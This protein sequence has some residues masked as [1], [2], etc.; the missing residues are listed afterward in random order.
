MATDSGLWDLLLRGESHGTLHHW[1]GDGF[2][3]QPW[4]EV[5]VQAHGMAATLREAGVRPGTRVATVLTNSAHTVRGLLAVWLAG[6]AVASFPLSARGQ[7]P[8]EYGNQLT[9]L[10]ERL[11]PTVLLVDESLKRLVPA[12]LAA[13]L[14]MLT[15]TSLYGGG[16]ID[17]SPPGDE[18]TVFI[19][20]SSGST[21]LP[22]GCELS[23]RAVGTHLHMLRELSDGQPGQETIASWLPLSH[24][25]GV[26]GTMLHAWAFDHDFV[27]SSPERFGMA[28]RTWFRDMSEFGAT[29]TA[30]TNTALHLATRAQGRTALPK[31]LRLKAFVMGAERV[32][33]DTLNAA[34]ETFRP[35]GLVPEAFMP[36]Y[37]MA[38]ATLA[39]SSTP[40]GERPSARHF[41]GAALLD[42]RIVEV[43]EDTPGATRLVS[44]GP[45][46]PGV[47]VQQARTGR[48]SELLISTPS[49]AS[50]YHGDPRRTAE[51]FR[52]G[53]LHTGDLGFV[54]D[55]EVFVVGRADDLISVGGRNVHTGDI[56]S[57]VEGLGTVRKG[58]SALVEMT[59]SPVSRLVMLLEPARRSDD[60]HAI[61]NRAAT[62]ALGKSGIALSECVFVERGHL[63][64]TPSGKIQR[65]RCR[66][67]LG[68]DDSP[69]K[70]I[71]RIRLD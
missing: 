13:R 2:A 42:N 33:W 49:L 56:E 24:D 59:G 15:W 50:R 53:A 20:Y 29:M 44:N 62:V 31:P 16:R 38:E 43:S 30:G 9:V 26:F 11:D 66:S 34:V 69:L 12:G 22:K 28:P 36:A 23:V 61:A 57:A 25:M 7:S 68:Q 21:S 47:R 55:G 18:D 51:R 5:V 4:H 3:H 63:P 70:T 64:R 71:A 65:F 58:C 17:P 27:L 54:H 45:P 39:I 48:V 32:D 37:G 67:L 6:G 19:Q 46:L 52:D 60:F 35:S 1:D 40:L 10:S 14:P 8:E 41:D